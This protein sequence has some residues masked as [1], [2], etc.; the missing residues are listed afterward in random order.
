MRS[1]KRIET[2]LLTLHNQFQAKDIWFTEGSYVSWNPSFSGMMRE[3][4][5]VPR[6]W[7]KS[8][9]LWNLALNQNNGPSFLSTA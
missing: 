7:A 1:F 3:M 5:A 9:I 6:N 2:N 8:Y 4:I